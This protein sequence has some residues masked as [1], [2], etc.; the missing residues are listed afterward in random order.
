MSRSRFSEPSR[1]QAN[2][3]FQETL[4]KAWHQSQ[5]TVAPGIAK[6]MGLEDE[7]HKSR[8]GESSGKLWSDLCSIAMAVQWL[9]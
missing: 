6:A 8:V 9:R 7:F 1:A 5:W 4:N 3:R 2:M